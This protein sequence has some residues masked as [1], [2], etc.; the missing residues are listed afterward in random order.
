MGAINEG[1]YYMDEPHWH[2]ENCQWEG[3]Q[4]DL[5][6]DASEEPVCPFCSSKNMWMEKSQEEE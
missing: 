1:D 2:C 4:D 5:A 6:F 3:S